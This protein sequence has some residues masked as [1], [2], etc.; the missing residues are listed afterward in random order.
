MVHEAMAT[1]AS[2][3]GR[4]SLPLSNPN[5]NF[6]RIAVNTLRRLG[7]R[8]QDLDHAAYELVGKLVQTITGRDGALFHFPK[9]LAKKGEGKA[10]F[11]KYFLLNVDQKGRQLRQKDVEQKG[12]RGLSISHGSSE[13]YGDIPEGQLPGGESAY[14]EAARLDEI[15]KRERVFAGIPSL[16]AD[17]RG[18]EELVAIWDMMKR[19][20]HTLREM[21]EELNAKGSPTI[22]GGP[23][24]TGVVSRAKIKITNLVKQYLQMKG[25]DW[26][27]V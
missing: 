23:W 21:A 11:D 26:N 15:A 25:I 27:S 5:V 13:E 12:Q 1:I 19:G 16:L 18:G 20:D 3:M 22:E 6:Y 14:D 10:F 4:D 9:Y 2:R 24:N 17:R 7:F 8:G